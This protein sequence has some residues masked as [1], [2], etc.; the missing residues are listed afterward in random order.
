MPVGKYDKD[1]IPFIQHTVAL[2][3]DDILYTLTDGMADQFGGPQGKKFMSKPLKALLLSIAHLP[4]Q[5]QRETLKTSLNDWKG[6]LEQV[7]DICLIGIK[8]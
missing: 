1:S 5:M 2:Q 6:N 3:K 8:V 4:M 7:D